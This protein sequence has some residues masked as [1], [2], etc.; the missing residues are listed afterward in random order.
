MAEDR[1]QAI[2]LDY[3]LGIAI[4]AIL[5]TG[6][7]IAGSGFVEDQ[8]SSAIRA[9]LEVVGQQVATD[10]EAADRLVASGETNT[11]VRVERRL[12]SEIAGSEYL[13]E[14]EGGAD[15]Q[16]VLTS[17]AMNLSTSMSVSAETAIEDS[18][19]F[20]GTISITLTDAGLL[21]LDGSDD[22]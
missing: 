14:L 18:R 17:N 22:T 7:L 19:A 4:A 9:E 15:P 5:V 21:R 11:T 16:V 12:P 20:G 3:T 10:V 13:I 1:G 2:T 6:L 8:R